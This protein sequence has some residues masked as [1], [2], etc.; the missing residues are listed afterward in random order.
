[1]EHKNKCEAEDLK[2]PAGFLRVRGNLT[3]NVFFFLF[4]LLLQ[5]GQ[6]RLTLLIDSEGD[7]VE[8]ETGGLQSQGVQCQESHHRLAV[9][10]RAE[11]HTGDWGSAESIE[12]AIQWFSFK[13]E[14]YIY[15]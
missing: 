7:C 15:F 14:L 6:E 10:E 3:G 8:V 13:T 1:M 11:E 5:V 12:K 9:R 2:G 4:H